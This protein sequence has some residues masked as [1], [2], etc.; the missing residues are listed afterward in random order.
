MRDGSD[1][2]ADW[3]ILNALLNTAAGATWV[4]VHH[5]GGVGIGN[6]IHAGMVVV[7]DGT[8]DAA[9]RL[10]RVLTADPGTGVMRHADAGYD[11]A[12]AAAPS[13]PSTCRSLESPSLDRPGPGL[14]RRRLARAAPADP[15]P[16]PAR[17]PGRPRRA[18]ARQRA[19]RRRL[20]RRRL[21][22]LR[23]APR[24][25]PSAG[26][27]S[28]GRSRATWR[29]STAAACARS[30]GSST[31]TRIRRSAATGS[32]SSRSGRPARATRSC[33]R[34]AAGSSRPSAR[35]ARPAQAACTRAV[36]RHRDWMLRGRDD[37]VGGQ[38]G[39]RARSRDGARARCARSARRAGSRPGSARTPS[40]PST[41]MRDAYLDF[42]LADVLPEAAAL[43]EAADVFLERGAFDAAQAR[44]YLEACR[45]RRPRAPAARRPVHG[46][47]R[48]PARDRAR[49]ALG[50]PPRGDRARTASRAL[51]ASDV[52]GVLLPGERALPRPADAAGAGARRRGRR[53]RARDRLQPRQLVL[54]EPAARLLA[55]GDAAGAQPGRGARR[56]HGQ[57]RARARPRRDDR[58]ARARATA[59]T[60]CCSTRPTGATSP[61]T[62][63]GRSSPACRGRRCRRLG[64]GQSRSSVATAASSADRNAS[65][66][67]PI[68][69]S[70]ARSSRSTASEPLCAT[71]TGAEP[72][73]AAARRR[74]GRSGGSAR[75]APGSEARNVS[76]CRPLAHAPVSEAAEGA[77]TS[78]ARS[79]DRVGS[80]P[81]IPPRAS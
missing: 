46:S 80:S 31:A 63:A 79:A 73:A 18:A 5:G 67:P 26:C 76:P 23:R 6:S 27:A 40:R 64:A 33:T 37:D 10:E 38:V 55:R 22:P 29:S 71:T 16:R 21:R 61:T 12:L 42:V 9:E 45:G 20:D 34:P 2:I 24:S 47:G 8:D 4:S 49:R 56:L 75:P 69:S 44:R 36:D 68:R 15:R 1:A 65:R 57:R 25:R 81:T 50:R 52:V 53:G 78:A 60:S 51:A 43:A 7:A 30:R 77:M 14:T 70:S 54:R 11:E 3:P 35:R 59:R 17:E 28:S 19:R 66:S 62:S 74:A 32:T 41:T 72:R 39:L 48:D 58:P 13:T